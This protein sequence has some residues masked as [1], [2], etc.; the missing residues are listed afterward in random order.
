MNEA[1]ICVKQ[2]GIEYDIQDHNKVYK[3]TNSEPS[4][5]RT[6]T[7]TDGFYFDPND[8]TDHCDHLVIG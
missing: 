6:L 5:V 1:F 7:C 3:C 2:N 4:V 8:K